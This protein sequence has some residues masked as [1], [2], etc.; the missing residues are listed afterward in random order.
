MR[1]PTA[2]RLAAIAVI[3]SLLTACGGGDGGT[4]PLSGWVDV[5]GMICADGSPTGI[6]ISPGSANRVLVFL[7]GGGACWGETACDASP[8]PFGSADY[9]FLSAF[10]LGTIFDRTLPGNP[11]ADWTLVF[12]PYCTGDVHAGD[13]EQTY[14]T[15]TWRH[16]GR[17]NLEAALGEVAAALPVPEK[18]VISGSSAGGFGSLLAFD[19]LRAHWPA[20]GA[21]TA[22]AYLVDDSGPT[23]VANDLPATLR[24]TWWANWNLAATVDPLCAACSGDLSELW[25]TL[26][27]AHPQDRLAFLTTTQ[28]AT[29]RGFFGGMAP[30]TFET[31][32]GT[33]T[34][35]IGG[36]A[37]GKAASFTVGNSTAH[38]LFLAPA[39]Y[40][41]GG[42]PLL[43]WL[44]L[45]VTDDPGWTSVGPP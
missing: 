14:G 27:A 3:V 21:G 29:M 33:L 10:T 38:A 19:L 18:V 7:N 17:A 15:A 13:S 42:E 32:I 2:P 1:V 22:Q 31:A 36:L 37:G 26:S 45:L 4:P 5:P 34:A 41:A 11:F 40:T 28:D 8:G 24:D 39:A 16:H 30:A 25:M 12:V 23:L 9:Q 6:G 35:K 20:G 43:G 44:D